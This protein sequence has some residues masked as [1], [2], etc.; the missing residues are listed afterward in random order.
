MISGDCKAN[1]HVW[2][3]E[4]TGADL[5]RGGRNPERR[6]SPKTNAGSRQTHLCGYMDYFVEGLAESGIEAAEA[7]R[8][9]IAKSRI[10]FYRKNTRPR[11]DIQKRDRYYYRDTKHFGKS[12]HLEVFDKRGKHLGEADPQTEE[13]RLG[14]ADST[15]KLEL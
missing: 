10:S 9:C 6:T 5:F 1:I 13:I 2:A 12:A 4:R 15:K 7:L 3:L 11:K 8:D 14:T